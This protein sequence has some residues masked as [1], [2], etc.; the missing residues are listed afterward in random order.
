[1]RIAHASQVSPSGASAHRD[2]GI[3][4]R[5]L[6]HGVE[7]TPGNYALM[8]VEAENYRAPRHRHNF[9]QVRVMLDG[10]FG[11]DRGQ[12]QRAGMIGYFTEGTYYTQDGEG[13]STTLLLQSGG[14]SGAGYMSDRQLRG[15]I[16]ELA[17]HGRFEHGVYTRFDERGQKHNQDGYEAAWEHVRGRAIEYPAPLYDA[18][19]LWHE[20]AYPWQPISQNDVSVREF[21]SFTAKALSISQYQVRPSQ[22][23]GAFRVPTLDRERLLYVSAGRGYIGEETIKQG[24][25]IAIDANEVTEIAVTDTIML[26]AIALMRW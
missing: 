21:G 10:E 17:T 1:M 4:M 8:L 12:V 14:A 6:L 2:G 18:P 26:Y 22:N 20:A 9:D 5:H 24:S 25:A 7:N 19:I 15:A 3:V 23:G 13:K 16:A 11:F